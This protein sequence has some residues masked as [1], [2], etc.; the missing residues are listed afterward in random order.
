MM[1]PKETPLQID[2]HEL[3][4]WLKE[5]RRLVLLDVRQPREIEICQ[6]PGALHIA[7]HELPRRVEQL[8][9]N[10]TIVVYCHHGGRSMQATRWLRAEGF[11]RVAN[12]AGGIDAWSRQID[13]AVPTY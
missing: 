8:D 7:L 4:S 1:S 3:A 2:V 13:P 5:G 6:L 10:E 11:E 9:P 12:L